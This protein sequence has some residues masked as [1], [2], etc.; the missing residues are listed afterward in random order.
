MENSF[1]VTLKEA[2]DKLGRISQFPE[3]L[4]LGKLV[5]AAVAAD[6]SQLRVTIGAREMVARIHFSDPASSH[7]D[8]QS[9]LA[10]AVA[11]AHK[12]EPS[13]L[14]W[15]GGAQQVDFVA[16]PPP[17]TRLEATGVATFRFV[18]T[19]WNLWRELSC[20]LGARGEAHSFLAKQACLSPLPIFLDA[21]RVNTP[22][23]TAWGPH[24]A[25]YLA[26]PGCQPHLQMLAP[27]P[28]E[29]SPSRVKMG[30]QEIVCEMTPFSRELPTFFL[31]GAAD[32]RLEHTRVEP[33]QY[34]IPERTHPLAMSLCGAGDLVSQGDR[35]VFV[36]REQWEWLNPS[37]HFNRATTRKGELPSLAALQ[38]F[39]FDPNSTRVS[40]FWPIQHGL[41]LEPV[42][43]E[44]APPG[45]R[46]IAVA[47]HLRLR[48]D[49]VT[50]KDTDA[51][52]DLKAQLGKQI[53]A[54]YKEM[55][56]D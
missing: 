5:Q 28:P 41:L 33:G 53:Q 9:Y 10:M 21:A 20:L 16:G 12:T 14:S 3:G 50:V 30:A 45:C 31:E 47:N 38:W 37:A 24:H 1:R 19:G 52:A 46:V 17:E 39:N 36:L 29:V 11:L 13:H 4:M 55:N 27:C 54:L 23:I 42:L 35:S 8:V 51:L 15:N 40:E 7:T 6:A 25:V 2:Q 18:R 49:Q 43:L 22:K 56:C 44:Q 48:A 32:A 26:A 34:S